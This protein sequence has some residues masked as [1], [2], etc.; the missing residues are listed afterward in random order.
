MYLCS[1]RENRLTGGAFPPPG[2]L[3]C[4]V[5]CLRRDVE[6]DACPVM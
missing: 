4:F 1:F 2:N 3:G 6:D 5:R